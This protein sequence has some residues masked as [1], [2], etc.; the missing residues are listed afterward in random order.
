VVAHHALA[1]VDDAPS[2]AGQEP[3]RRDGVEVTPRVHPIAT[4]H[5][6]TIACSWLVPMPLT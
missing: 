1:V 3:A 5:A 2:V 4:R 6:A